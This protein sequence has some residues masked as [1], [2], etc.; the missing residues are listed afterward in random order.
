[1]CMIFLRVVRVY[2]ENYCYN[3]EY[4][5]IK[6]AFYIKYFRGDKIIISYDNI[7]QIW[8]INLQYNKYLCYSVLLIL[9]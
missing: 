5:R 9:L 4:I 7:V 8:I 3:D 2:F 6:K 1:M